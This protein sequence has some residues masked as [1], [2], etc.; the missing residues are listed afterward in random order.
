MRTAVSLLLVISGFATFLSF[1][2]AFAAHLVLQFHVE[3]RGG[4]GSRDPRS[5]FAPVDS[6]SRDAGGFWKIRD[7]SFKIFALACGV[8]ALLALL[9]TVLDIH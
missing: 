9:V 3:R 8:T 2:A 6:Y 4:D 1:L 7:R 5:I